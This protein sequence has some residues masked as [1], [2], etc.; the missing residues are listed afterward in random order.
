MNAHR[1]KFYENRG[2]VEAVR[3]S[4]FTESSH[5]PWYKILAGNFRVSRKFRDRLDCY[6]GVR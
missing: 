2:A 4:A 6:V 3:E 5:E 1:R